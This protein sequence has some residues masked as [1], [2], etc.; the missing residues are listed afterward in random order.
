MW[1]Q[2]VRPAIG[3]SVMRSVALAGLSAIALGGSLPVQAQ[4][5]E[6][7]SS[8]DVV[9]LL[10]PDPN[11]EI[12]S[13]EVVEIVR[14]R[15]RVRLSDGT[16]RLLGLT[17]IDRDRLSL[18]SGDPITVALSSRSFF[19]QA[20]ERGLA[21]FGRDTAGRIVRNS[22]TSVT[23][24]PTGTVTSTSTVG[25]TVTDGSASTTVRTGGTIT[26]GSSSSTTTGSTTTIRTERRIIQQEEVRPAATVQTERRVIQQEVRQEEVRPA[27]PVRGLW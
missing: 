22:S 3:R 15:A 12:V 5:A 7:I 20:V 13:G 11:L 6:V 27:Q 16:T 9:W 2:W 23:L 10:D 8:P 1:M 24:T 18:Q 14:D 21:S 26:S 19:A 17:K 25:G 4:T